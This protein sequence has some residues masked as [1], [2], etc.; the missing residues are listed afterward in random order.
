ME[1]VTEIVKRVEQSLPRPVSTITESRTPN[2]QAECAACD[3]NGWISDNGSTKPCACQREKRIER[4]LPLRYR[5][6]KLSDFSLKVQEHVGRWLRSPGEGLLLSGVVGSGKT[7]LAA[8]IVRERVEHGSAASFRRMS[9]L[10]TA[11]R[12]SFHTNVSEAE[13]LR[14][15]LSAP[16]IVLD[17][18]GAGGLSDFERRSTLEILDQRQNA[19]RPTIVTT[20]WELPDIA[21]KMDDRIASRLAPYTNLRLVG[22]DRRLAFA[23]VGGR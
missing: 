21:E 1:A 7:Y 6:A 14:P 22:A 4:E 5:R 11:L 16:L 10:Y 18:L 19:M 23:A 13:V 20:N 17:D 3:G 12:E 9:E 2:S 8:A 15:Y